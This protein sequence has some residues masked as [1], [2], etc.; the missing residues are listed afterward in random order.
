MSW[1]KPS[2]GLAP[3]YFRVT[4]ACVIFWHREGFDSFYLERNLVL[5]CTEARVLFE[6]CP[7]A[8]EDARFLASVTSHGNSPEMELKQKRVPAPRALS[9]ASFM[10][11][12][13]HQVT[14]CQ[15]TGS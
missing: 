6:S 7:P 8:M 1:L 13:V 5:L 2:Q 10:L 15:Q 11:P 4:R 14:C 9:L 3:W 12:C